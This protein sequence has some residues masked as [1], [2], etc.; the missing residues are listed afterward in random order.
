MGWTHGQ[1]ERRK[2][3]EEISDKETGMLKKMT[4]STAKMGGKRHTKGSGRIN[5]EENG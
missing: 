5:V 3:P 4:Q 1:G 2:I